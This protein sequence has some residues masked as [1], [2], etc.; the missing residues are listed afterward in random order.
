[1]AN[2]EDMERKENSPRFAIIGK[3]HLILQTS[4][5]HLSPSSKTVNDEAGAGSRGNTYAKAVYQSKLGVIASVADP[6]A[7]KRQSLGKKYIW[8]ETDKQE[9]AEFDSWQDFLE[10]EQMRRKRQ[11]SGEHVA[12]GVDGIFICT[13]DHTHK[14]I[15]IAF[16]PLELHIMSEKPLATSLQ[17][18]IDIYKTIK[19]R[20]GQLQKTIFSVGHVLRYSPHNMLLYQL[21]LKE[22]VIGDV[23]SIE[24]TEPVGWSHF[25]HSYVR[26]VKLRARM[27]MS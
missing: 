22:R 5:H 4:H 3:Y 2:I 9:D 12:P 11:A 14:E 18:C 8:S 7:S 10:Y 6:I 20:K 27:R 26:S 24:H 17:D 13:L 21:L 1:M 16:A 23:I 15:I 19:P 25:S